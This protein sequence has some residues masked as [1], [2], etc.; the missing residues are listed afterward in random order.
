MKLSTET[1]ALLTNFSKFQKGIIIQPGNTLGI[2]TEYVYAQAN[3][4]E[5][6]PTEARISDVRDFLQMVALFRDPDIDFS[7][8]PIRIA[9]SDGT[10]ELLYPQA[11]PELPISLPFPKRMKPDPP[12]Q[13]TFTI[14][15]VQWAAIQKALGITAARKKDDWVRRHLVVLSD[16]KNIRLNTERGR[17]LPPYSLWP[18]GETK[19]IECKS[20]FDASTL[21]LIGGSY[22]VMLTATYARF[23]HAGTYDVRYF[24]ATARTSTWG[25]K[26]T[27]VVTATK[28]L[29]HECQFNIQANSPEEAEAIARQKPAEEFRWSEEPHLNATFKAVA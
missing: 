17:S 8:D 12:E 3:V 5:T 21:H 7:S 25:G 2:R 18:S 13:I 19:G 9:E 26:R 4:S 10:A 23:V 27:Y 22:N 24:V 11:K 20:V 15:D 29:T 14:S 1:T 6:F 16:G 28:H